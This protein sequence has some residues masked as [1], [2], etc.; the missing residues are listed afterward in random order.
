MTKH[1]MDTEVLQRCTCVGVNWIL[2]YTMDGHGI[3]LCINVLEMETLQGTFV[4]SVRSVF[5]WNMYF[6]SAKLQY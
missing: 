6:G 2:G 4:Q 1:D 5:L 3:L